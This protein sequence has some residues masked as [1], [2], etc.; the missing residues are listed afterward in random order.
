MLQDATRNIML[1]LLAQRECFKKADVT[2]LAGP[3]VRGL[4]RLRVHGPCRPPCCCH[5]ELQ[6][7]A[8]TDTV[9]NK[10]SATA[11]HLLCSCAQQPDGMRQP[12][13]VVKD[14]CISKNQSWY[15]KQGW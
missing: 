5:V 2:Q 15:L 1:E 3:L 12:L 4:V 7:I 14:L 6:G 9:Y 8:I 13:Q 10:A 11:S